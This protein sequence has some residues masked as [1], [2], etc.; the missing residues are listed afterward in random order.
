VQVADAE[1]VELWAVGGAVRDLAAGLPVRDLDLAADVDPAALASEVAAAVGAEQQGEA[2]FGTASVHRLGYRLDLAALRTE[3]YARPGA[4]PSVQLGASIEDDLGR[5]D[6]TVN[7]TALGVTARRYDEVVDPFDG[8][9]D[10]AGRRLRVLHE[11]AFVDDATRLWRGARYAVRLGLR[12]DA[13]TAQLIETGGRWLAPVSARRIWNEFERLAAER[14]IGATL[15]LLDQW[16]VLTATHPE[17]QFVLPSRRGIMRRRGPLA[18]ELLLAVLLAPLPE[19][20][21]S[22]IA[23]RVGAPRRAL[24]AVAD[25]CRLIAA[26][27]HD[28]ESLEAVSATGEAGRMAALWLDPSRQRGFQRDLRRWER[29]AAPLAAR[30][31]MALGLQGAEVG[32]ALRRLRR[33]R[34]LGTLTGPADARRL[35]LAPARDEKMDA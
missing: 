28:P 11:R 7:A 16:G 20:S 31:L 26:S 3:R 4:L 29:T 15:A 25:A 23:T 1:H 17:F 27:D 22:A 8:L 18:P 9:A 24:Q 21:Q 10:L 14:Q 33:A 35:A 30:E 5:R 19:A 2:R 12:P 13:A 6:F 32:R 34:Y